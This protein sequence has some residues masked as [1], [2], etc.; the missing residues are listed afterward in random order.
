MATFHSTLSTRAAIGK[1]YY[2]EGVPQMR[3][4]PWVKNKKDG[5]KATKTA[6]ETEETHSESSTKPAAPGAH[7]KSATEPTSVVTPMGGLHKKASAGPGGAHKMQ[8]APAGGAHKKVKV[9]GGAH[10]KRPV[11]AAPAAIEAPA[12]A[13][14]ALVSEGA[15]SKPS[16]LP[17]GGVHSKSAQPGADLGTRPVGGAHKITTGGVH[18][19]QP[20]S[21]PQPMTHGTD[22]APGAQR[23]VI[24]AANTKVAGRTTAA[25]RPPSKYSRIDELRSRSV[26]PP[27]N[28]DPFNLGGGSGSVGAL[29]RTRGDRFKQ[30]GQRL[31]LWAAS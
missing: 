28:A 29:A 24:H 30:V 15:H 8:P 21:T 2:K 31:K 20:V 6:Q 27:E 9:A 22:L 14:P 13:A 1:Q 17:V 11:V 7:K 12:A 25:T 4:V 18:R 16:T 3:S 26:S 10:K 19:F 23:D 5:G